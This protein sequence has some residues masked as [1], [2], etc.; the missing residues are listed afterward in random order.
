MGE[1]L[2]NPAVLPALDIL[3]HPYGL[4]LSRLK[5][6]ELVMVVVAVAAAAAAAAGSNCATLLLGSFVIQHP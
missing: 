4:G 6:R 2:H 3:C 1:P 5:V